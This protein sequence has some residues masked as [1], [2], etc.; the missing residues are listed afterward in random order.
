MGTRNQVKELKYDNST[1]AEESGS[2][3]T[4]T[5]TVLDQSYQINVT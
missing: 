4:V 1:V 2:L 3:Q 5:V